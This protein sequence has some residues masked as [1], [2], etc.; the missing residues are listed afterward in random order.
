MAGVSRHVAVQ[1]VLDDR[2]PVALR[3]ISVAAGA[4]KTE[5][6][7]VAPLELA[8]LL[9]GQ[10]LRIALGVEHGLPEPAGGAAEEAIGL[11]DVPIAKQGHDRVVVSKLDILAH[12]QTAP[13]PAGAA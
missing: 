4:R 2:A 11:E 9:G 13:M 8:D 6:D 5:A 10:G 7:D 1:D 12:A 3:R